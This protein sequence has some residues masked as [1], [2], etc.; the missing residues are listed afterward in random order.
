MMGYYRSIIYWFAT[1]NK[2]NAILHAQL[3]YYC[4]AL[5]F[6]TRIP[7][8][9]WAIINADTL[10]QAVRYFP[11][12]GATI[13]VL[14]ALVF[15][16]SY[17]VLPLPVALL[18]SLLATLCL[19]GALHEDGLAD[20]CDGLGGGSDKGAVL[21]IMKDSRLGS[22]GVLGLGLVIALK[23]TAL[24]AMTAPQ[25]V[26]AL[27]VGHAW[28]RLFAI[29][30]M[31]D[32][33]YIGDISGNSVYPSKIPAL[34]APLQPLA[35]GLA[36]LTVLPL[37]WFISLVQCLLIVVGL[38]LLRIGVARLLQQ[39]LGGYNGDCLGAAQQLAEVLIYLLLLAVNR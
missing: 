7:L 29:S 28:S 2:L 18:L 14:A 16:L 5:S 4:T 12:V 24:A 26:V 8:P 25:I 21:A 20:Y 9:Q 3:Q 19:T 33:S 36:L 38:S 11:L 39:R 1:V 17:V 37:A 10:R 13:G 6:L 27:V 30:F 22:Y 31:I 35:F 23:I 32:Y 15:A 34:A